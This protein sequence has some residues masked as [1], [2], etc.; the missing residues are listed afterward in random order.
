[1]QEILENIRFVD[2]NLSME[3]GY[4]TKILSFFVVLFFVLNI[5]SLSF[6]FK[7]KN[8]SASGSVA[9]KF[10]A[11]I[12]MT[13][14]VLSTMFPQTAQN[15]HQTKKANKDSNKNFVKIN[16]YIGTANLTITML[17]L[18][19]IFVV[20][21]IKNSTNFIPELKSYP[22]KIP[23]RLSVFL[24]LLMKILFNVLPRSISINYNK[25]HIERACIV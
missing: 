2:Y 23:L 13:I 1:M 17:N 18:I 12:N 3:T 14:D 6:C 16:E 15:K 10:F 11:S 25:K 5:F 8:I 24:L 9:G 19:L 20:Y 7:K 21:K 4:K 22:L